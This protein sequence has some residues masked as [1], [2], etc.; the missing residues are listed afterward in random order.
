MPASL[1]KRLPTGNST[2]PSVV[3]HGRGRSTS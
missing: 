1:S 2:V 3:E